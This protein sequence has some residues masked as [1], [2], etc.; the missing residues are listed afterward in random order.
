MES[1]GVPFLALPLLRGMAEKVGFAP[2]S[3]PLSELAN[4][5][6]VFYA[7][8]QDILFVCQRAKG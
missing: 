2:I 7:G 5:E 3:T 4:G 1:D 8:R 6:G